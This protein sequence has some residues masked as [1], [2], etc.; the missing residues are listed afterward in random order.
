M[1]VSFLTKTCLFNYFFLFCFTEKK[2]SF[3]SADELAKM[4]EEE[5]KKLINFLDIMFIILTALH[6][7][8]EGL[9]THV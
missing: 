2:F 4:K 5:G 7:A 3:L 6:S 9:L 1:K 8:H